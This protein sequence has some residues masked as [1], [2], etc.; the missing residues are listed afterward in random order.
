[1]SKNVKN[2]IPKQNQKVEKWNVS[3]RTKAPKLFV[4]NDLDFPR[5][6]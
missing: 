2:K 3:A 5:Y 6:G 4:Q 1:M